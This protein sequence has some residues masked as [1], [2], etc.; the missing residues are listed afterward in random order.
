MPDEV[1]NFAPTD[2]NTI[3][4]VGNDFRDVVFNSSSIDSIMERR[5]GHDYPSGGSGND[6]FFVIGGVDFSIGGES[7]NRIYGDA[8]EDEL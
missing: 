5:G 2:V 3:Q 6:M 8:G 4:P 7:N 1:T